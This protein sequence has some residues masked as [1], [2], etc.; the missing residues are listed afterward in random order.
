MSGSRRFGIGGFSGCGGKDRGLLDF[1]GLYFERHHIRRADFD[2]FAIQVALVQEAQV[3]QGFTVN[4]FQ[5]A[6]IAMRDA[7]QGEA[8]KALVVLKPGAALT[9]AE[10]IAWCRD[11]MAVYKAPRFVEFVPQLPK[12]NTGKILWRDLQQRE[13]AQ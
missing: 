11:A 5:H 1:A 13:L 10:L 6:A 7:R 4:H 3:D 9:D 12:S 2:A 8:V